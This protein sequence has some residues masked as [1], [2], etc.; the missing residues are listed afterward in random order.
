MLFRV[1]DHYNDNNYQIIK[2][3]EFENLEIVDDVC[4]ICFDYN[5]NNTIPIRL[6]NK[7]YHKSCRCDG[8]VHLNCLDLWHEINPVCP[9]CRTNIYKIS[10]EISRIYYVNYYIFLFIH[11]IRYIIQSSINIFDKLKNIIICLWLL[12]FFLNCVLYY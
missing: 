11:Y 5:N 12:C 3:N 9:I 8:F 6:N 10:V 1:M 4:F 2:K 7:C